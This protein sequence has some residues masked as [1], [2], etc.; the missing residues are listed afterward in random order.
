VTAVLSL[1]A[2]VPSDTVVI[3]LVTKVAVLSLIGAEPSDNS[4]ITDSS[5]A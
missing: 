4:G 3:H 5:C 2:A 1:I